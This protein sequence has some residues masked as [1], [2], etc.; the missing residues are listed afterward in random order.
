MLQTVQLDSLLPQNQTQQFSVQKTSGSGESFLDLV[1][2]NQEKTGEAQK[3]VFPIKRQ[4]KN[5]QKSR[6]KNRKTL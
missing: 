5:R 4:N 2:F 6:K 1:R 3:T